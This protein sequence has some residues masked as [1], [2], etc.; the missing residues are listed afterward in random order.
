MSWRESYLPD[1]LRVS[2]VRTLDGH[3]VFLRVLLAVKTHG[4]HFFRTRYT[5][6]NV[7][8]PQASWNRSNNLNTEHRARKLNTS[9]RVLVVSEPTTD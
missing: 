1:G 4:H 9:T 2:E 6:G 8:F 7:R 3:S 5:P